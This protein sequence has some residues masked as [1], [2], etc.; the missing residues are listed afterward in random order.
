MSVSWSRTPD[1]AEYACYLPLPLHYLSYLSFIPV[2]TAMSSSIPEIGE[3]AEFVR[4]IRSL[5]KSDTNSSQP[6][7]FASLMWT[8]GDEAISKTVPETLQIGELDERPVYAYL[9]RPGTRTGSDVLDLFTGDDTDKKSVPRAKLHQVSFEVP[10]KYICLQ[11]DYPLGEECPLRAFILA[12]YILRGHTKN[13]STKT[14]AIVISGLQQALLDVDEG[15]I[16]KGKGKAVTG[17]T[18]SASSSSRPNIVGRASQTNWREGHRLEA[19][20]ASLRKNFGYE[21][22]PY[23]NLLIWKSTNMIGAPEKLQIGTR[24]GHPVFAIFDPRAPSKWQQLRI[25]EGDGAEPKK[26]ISKNTMSSVNFLK[27]YSYIKIDDSKPDFA[28]KFR[29]FLKGCFVLR[30]HSD[31]RPISIDLVSFVQKVREIKKQGFDAESKLGSGG[32]SDAT[33]PLCKALGSNEV[34]DCLLEYLA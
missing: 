34:R 31:D 1:R 7:F 5:L 20:Q 33:D 26:E 16:T 18:T 32:A 19:V 4:T 27:P 6:T 10:F 17:N 21:T 14:R 29:S 9:I 15:L 30:G 8:P 3:S 12:C 22:L 24:Q 13:F 28:Q 2:K 11:T 25:F 23:L